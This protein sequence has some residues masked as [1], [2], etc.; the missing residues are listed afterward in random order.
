L[1]EQLAECEREAY[2]GSNA[3]EYDNLLKKIEQLKREVKQ[4]ATEYLDASFESRFLAV[5]VLDVQL[6]VATKMHFIDRAQGSF[7][8]MYQQL[9]GWR[10][11]LN[12]ILQELS[13]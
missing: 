11:C 10:T 1:L 12:E 2:D 5:N 3:S 9:K 6:D 7:W 8:T 13:R 4:I